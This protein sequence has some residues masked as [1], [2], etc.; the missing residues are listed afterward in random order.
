MTREVFEAGR[1]LRIAIH[2]HPIVGR[3]RVASSKALG[4]F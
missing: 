3:D 2:D 4:L 1:S